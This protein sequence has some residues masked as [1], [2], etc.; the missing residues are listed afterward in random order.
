MKNNIGNFSLIINSISYY[1]YLS[2]IL[3]I[4]ILSFI[5]F[6]NVFYYKINIFKKIR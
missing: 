1:I 6:I 4:K 5:I 3:L 2:N